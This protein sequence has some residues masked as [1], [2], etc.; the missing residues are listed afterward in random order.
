[1]SKGSYT[2]FVS[3]MYVLNIISQAFFTL[4]F[5]I[6]LMAL[7]SWLL[8]KYAGAPGWIWAILIVLGAL[9]GLY[10]MIKFILS[11]M[12]ALD[13]LEAEHKAKL[14][15]DKI[16]NNTKNDNQTAKDQNEKE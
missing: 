8:C 1:M 2:K 11:A 4:A 9:S 6:G 16:G 7:L 13:K 15:Q 12:N 14:K 5:P 10:S 3:A